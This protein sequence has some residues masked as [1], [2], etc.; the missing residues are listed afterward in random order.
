M[1]FIH[2]T[3]W[4]LFLAPT[5]NIRFNDTKFIEILLAI[6]ILIDQA[7]ENFSLTLCNIA[8]SYSAKICPSHKKENKL[9]LRTF[10]KS[11]LLHKKKEKER[12]ESPEKVG[13]GQKSK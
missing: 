4:V 5:Q 13:N 8:Y 11:V 9:V 3:K 7:S 1:F 6:G 10:E 12:E 2:L